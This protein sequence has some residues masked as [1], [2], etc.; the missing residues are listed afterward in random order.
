MP[1][2]DRS[3][4]LAEASDEYL[5]RCVAARDRNAF[6]MVYDRFSRPV[7][8]MAGHMLGVN[9]AEEATQEIFM[10]LWH[11]ASQYDP[12]RGAFSHWFM[13]I[14]RNH[15]LDKLRAR[16][17]R[18]RVVAAEALDLLLAEAPD[19]KVDVLEQVWQNQRGDVLAQALQGIPAEQRRVIVLAYFGGMSQSEI[20]MHL[21]VPLGTVKK[22]IRLGLQK[23]RASLSPQVLLDFDGVTEDALAAV[24]S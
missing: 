3:I 23:L 1:V 20:A 11:K 12:A 24:E 6:A 16:T 10:R 13:S 15:I 8:A 21:N 17:E 14:A 9:E 22:R 2:A 4:V 5:A 18:Q 19:P 7:F